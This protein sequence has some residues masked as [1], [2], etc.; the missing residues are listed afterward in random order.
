MNKQLNIMIQ[1]ST[2]IVALALLP[3]CSLLEKFTNKKGQEAAPK[4]E[5]EATQNKETSLETALSQEQS[6]PVLLTINGKKVLYESE[7]IK[8]ITQMLQANPYFRGAGVDSLP[9]SIKK[10]FFDELVKQKIIIENAKTSNVFESAEF[11]KAYAEMMQLV[12]DSLTVQFFEKE[13][14]DTINVSDSDVSD[15]Y[16]KNKEQFVKVAGGVLVSGVKFD[17]ADSAKAFYAKAKSN[18]SEFESL[19]QE[20]K[21][22][23]YKSFGRIS[24]ES[25]DFSA[26][27]VPAPIKDAV[28][29]FSSYPMVKQVTSGKEH[30]VVVGSDKK[31]TEFFDLEEIKPQVNG[32]LKNNKFKEE[33]DKKLQGIKGN[34]RLIINEEYFKEKDAP[35]QTPEVDND[36]Q[37]LPVA[38]GKN[39]SATAA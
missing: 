18:P 27:L 17:N 1:G 20:E 15:Y 5:K 12:Q 32:M 13:V 39:T 25:K 10:K 23:K 33:L 34:M 8:S 7:F 35:L 19:A 4:T 24:K 3:S 6:G 22:G 21:G 26:N 31:E 37:S 2:L 28:L 11:K 14:F 38:Q 30:W 16:K 36:N 9:A 29:N